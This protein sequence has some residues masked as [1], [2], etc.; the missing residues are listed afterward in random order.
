MEIIFNCSHCGQEL[1]VDGE[2]VGTEIKCPTCDGKITIPDHPPETR[3]SPSSTTG[4]LILNPITQSAAAKVEMHLKVPVRDKPAESLLT[5]PKTPLEVVAKGL[6]KKLR[7]RTV[8]HVQCVEA[9]HDKF[10][11][12]MAEV[13]SEIGETNIVGI[14]IFNYDHL[15]VSTQKVLM[16]YGVM[17]VYRA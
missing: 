4:S 16:D 6:D 10:D 15:D 3:S 7:T 14:H 9:G 8:R 13:L 12:K 2:G 11:Q 5:K 1:S 17:V